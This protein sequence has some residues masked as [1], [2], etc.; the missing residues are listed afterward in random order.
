MS[1]DLEHLLNT[2]AAEPSRP[3][4][5]AEIIRLARRRRR[6]RRAT[7]IAGV[8]ATLAAVTAVMAPLYWGADNPVTE[9]AADPDRGDVAPPVA[10]RPES[11]AVPYAP[12]FDCPVTRPPTP[13]FEP[14]DGYPA[15]P[16]DQ[17]HAGPP[18]SDRSVWYGTEELWTV[19][20]VDG[21]YGQR[22]SVWWSTAFPGGNEE[23]RPQIDVTWERLDL[24][25]SAE[26]V[27]TTNGGR[28]TNAHTAEDGWFMIAG[29]DPTDPGCWQVTAEYKDAVLRYVYEISATDVLWND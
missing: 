17:A 5:P 23:G 20:P 13:G 24:R 16:S 28:G 6:R 19:L 21:A 29:I 25:D 2:T 1:R 14:P 4:D 9:P 26:Q 3:V 27:L 12:D 18:S 11:D 10:I 22:K 15:E 7:A 8:A